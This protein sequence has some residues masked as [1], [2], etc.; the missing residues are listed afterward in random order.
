MQILEGLNE[1]QVKAV[2][3][4]DGPLLILA[5]AGSGKTKTLT[6]RI[7]YLLQEKRIPQENILAA[8]FTNKAAKEMRERIAALLGYNAENRAFMPFMGTFHG[9]CVRILRMDADYIGLSR[10]FVIFDT[11]DQLATVK[12]AMK[13]LGV[14]E[15]EY[16]S[17]SI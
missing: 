2:K 8:T 14:V 12:Q 7:A 10:S 15:K 3:T 1:Q 11:N 13:E 9:L 5:G 6:H 17:R 16:S 4:V